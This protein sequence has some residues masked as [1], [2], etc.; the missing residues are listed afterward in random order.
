MVRQQQMKIEILKR[1]LKPFTT[2]EIDGDKKVIDLKK[3]INIKTKVS[4]PRQR[5]TIGTQP[6]IVVLD[7]DS[8][9]T[10]SEYGLKEGTQVIFKDLGPQIPFRPVYLIEYLGPLV[11]YPIFA[12]RLWLPFY[13]KDGDMSL[14]LAQ[15]LAFILWTAHYVKRQLETIFVHEFGTLTM[16]I[17]N[18]FKNCSYYYT[19]AL[20]VSWNVNIP[21][22]GVEAPTWR[23]YLGAAWFVL[24][25]FLNFVCHIMLSK[26]RAK[27]RNTIVLPRGFLFELVDAPNYFCEIMTW[28]GFNILTG[29]TLAGVAFNIVGMLQMI[30]WANKKHS[31]YKRLFG[32]KYP[33]NRKILF[34][35]IY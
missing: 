4:I 32:D 2:V 33:K 20:L 13:P 9:K 24:F 1:N 3:A 25:M 28:F 27:G 11:I 10:L 29:F 31:D 22:N 7:A 16:P 15:R 14:N 17:F 12:L 34:P 19:A 35:F 23:V 26:L 8:D 5:L 21:A 6:N 30:Q 18:L